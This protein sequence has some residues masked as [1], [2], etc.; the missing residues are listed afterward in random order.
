M[1]RDLLTSRLILAGLVFFVLVVSGS[2]FYSWY[3]RRTTEA[4]FA[5]TDTFLQHLENKRDA[6]VSQDFEPIDPDTLESS[7]TSIASDDTQAMSGEKNAL[8]LHN[9]DNV[10]TADALLRKDVVNTEAE[11]T[12]VPVSPFGFGPYPEVPADYFGV[13]IWNQDPDKI[14]DFPNEATKNIELIDRVLVKLWQQGDREIVG[15]STDNGKVYP[16]YENVVYVHWEE[17]ILP[18]GDR[19]SYVTSTLTGADEGPTIEDIMTGNIPPNFTI[20]DIDDAGYDAYQ[21]LNLED[22]GY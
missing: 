16:H 12:D 4:E 19:Y 17:S 6:D 18:N 7:E 13:P 9:T 3:M 5:Q 15:G 1:F 14:S 10:E 21:F 20:I 2:L 8:P 22:E 11:S